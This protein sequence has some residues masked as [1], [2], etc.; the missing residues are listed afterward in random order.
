MREKAVSVRKEREE[1]QRKRQ[2]ETQEQQFMLLPTVGTGGR[3][4]A[5]PEAEHHCLV[6]NHRTK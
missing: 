5:A 1:L 6:D 2:A 4:T 3:G